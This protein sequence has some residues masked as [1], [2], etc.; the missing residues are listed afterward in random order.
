MSVFN[1]LL[2]DRCWKER[3]PNREPG[4]LRADVGTCCVCKA[5]TTSGIYVRVDPAQMPCRG[6]GPQHAAQS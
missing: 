5:L 1:H 4:R 2:C 3:E 6:K